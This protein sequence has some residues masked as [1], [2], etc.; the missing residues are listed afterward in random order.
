MK[1][2]TATLVTITG[3][4]FGGARLATGAEDS[5]VGKWKLNPEKSQLSGL[6]YKV[7]DAGGNKY[8]FVFGDDA[9]MVTFDGKPH[10]TKYGSTWSVTKSG[11]NAWKWTIKRDGKLI[12]DATWTVSAD[13]ATSD[14]VNE[15]MR[16]DGTTSHNE[17]RLKRTGGTS[18]LVG[19][20]ESTEIKIGSP[21]TTEV[22]KWKDDG[23]SF[24]NPT[25][26]G[27]TEFKLDGKEYADKGPRVPKGA[28]VSAKRVDDRA[29]EV[30]NKLK[31]KT[32]EVDRYEVS[33]DGKTL[34]ETINYPGLDKP[35]VDVFDRQ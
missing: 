30:T 25:Y 23:Y 33:A 5:F 8:K 28:T 7:E 24:V 31:G 15:D 4:A 35:E 13:G 21:G 27:R 18:G 10:V 3:L 16:P 20:W 9:E 17:T 6:T 26:K 2:I 29:I 34:T 14:Y 1:I 22:A 19:T 12:S 11:A 32:V